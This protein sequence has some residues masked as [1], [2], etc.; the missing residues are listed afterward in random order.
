[1]WQYCWADWDQ[2]CWSCSTTCWCS[3]WSSGWSWCPASGGSWSSAVWPRSGRRSWWRSRWRGEEDLEIPEVNPPTVWR[4]F[5]FQVQNY[6]GRSGSWRCSA[7][8]LTRTDRRS[9]TRVWPPR[10]ELRT[11]RTVREHEREQYL[12]LIETC[13]E[14]ILSWEAK[15]LEISW[16]TATEILKG[17]DLTCCPSVPH[18]RRSHC[19]NQIQYFFSWPQWTV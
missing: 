7:R 13:E 16:M 3:S 15:T 19:Y 12:S 14:K 9:Q 8:S 18:W 6:D 5:E 4:V 11:T 17:L 2:T 10:S 1:M